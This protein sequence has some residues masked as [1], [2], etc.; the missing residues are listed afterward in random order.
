MSPKNLN[1]IKI[2]K[3]LKDKLSNKKIIK[4]GNSGDIVKLIQQSLLDLKYD[5]IGTADGKFGPKTKEGVQ[6][7]QKDNGLTD[8]GIVGPKTAQKIID[9]MNLTKEK[10]KVKGGVEFIEKVKTTLKDENLSPE[11]KQ[12]KIEK[13][14]KN[15][16]VNI[17]LDTNIDFSNLTKLK[18]PKEIEKKVDLVFNKLG[19]Q[20]VGEFDRN[21]QSESEISKPILNLMKR[22]NIIK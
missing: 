14:L 8:D 22:M 9:I 10:N 1:A 20:P 2:P 16:G 5:I 15:A 4:K 3:V 13:D 19:I 17:N 6:K 18:E 12:D 21:L 11:Q 7:F